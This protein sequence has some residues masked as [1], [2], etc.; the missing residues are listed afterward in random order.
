M[1]IDGRHLVLVP[2]LAHEAAALRN[3]SLSQIRGMAEPPNIPARL[4]TET[5]PTKC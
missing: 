2:S 4:L 3:P 5:F 1:Q